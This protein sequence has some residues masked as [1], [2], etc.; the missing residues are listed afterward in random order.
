MNFLRLFWDGFY[1][2]GEQLRHW[3]LPGPS[4]ELVRL[5]KVELAGSRGVA[6]DLGCGGGRDAIY[7]SEQGYRAIGV[8]VSIA[9]LSLARHRAAGA[10]ASVAWCLASVTEPPLGEDSVDLV[11]DR[12]CFHSLEDPARARYAAAVARILR[13]GGWLFLRGSRDEREEEGLFPVDRVTI[14]THLR[15]RGFA[16]EWLR[17]LVIVAPAGDLA[18]NAA[19]LRFAP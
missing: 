18:A 16:L 8:D 7:L 12:G 3:E 19:L 11:V 2:E 5:V 6:V 13:P 4:P 1:V 14:A 17:P 15:P 10:G 9:A